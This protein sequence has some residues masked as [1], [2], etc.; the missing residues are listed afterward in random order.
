MAQKPPAIVD[1]TWDGD[2]R[3]RVQVAPPP[4]GQLS[5]PAFLLDSTGQAGP[6]PVA[7][8]A[9]SLAGCMSIDLAHILSR[10]RHPVQDIRA[11]LE[12]ER[13]AEAP[14]RVTRVTLHFVVVGDVPHEAVARAIELSQQKYCS[15]WHSLRQD[16]DLQVTFDRTA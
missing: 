2:L 10:G 13:A 11:H 14:H 1:L 3:F 15:V 16:I 8:L 4:G 12:A 9:A 7:L 5:S 6:S